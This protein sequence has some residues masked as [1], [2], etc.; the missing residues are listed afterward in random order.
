M[1]LKISRTYL[2]ETW[3]FA[4]NDQPITIMTADGYVFD[5]I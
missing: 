4:L 5:T 2:N 1:D 3:S